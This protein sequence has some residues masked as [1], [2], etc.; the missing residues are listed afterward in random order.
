MGVLCLAIIFVWYMTKFRY[1]ILR[2]SMIHI[3]K[4]YINY[5][6]E[7]LFEINCRCLVW[8]DDLLFDMLLTD[9][10]KCKQG[11][12]ILMRPIFYKSAKESILSFWNDIW[13][14]FRNECEKYDIH[15][16]SGSHRLRISLWE[17]KFFMIKI[18]VN[19]SVSIP[20]ALI[21]NFRTQ[22]YNFI[23]HTKS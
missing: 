3:L 23:N 7:I 17:P 12:K 11:Y 2:W 1:D 15:L 19:K 20:T 4:W 18:F 5:L 22:T 13:L 8:K 10:Y 9:S 21:K 6:F 16:Q 14:S